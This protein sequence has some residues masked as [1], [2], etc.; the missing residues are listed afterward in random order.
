MR[1][2]QLYTALFFP[3]LEFFPT[4]FSL[5]KDPFFLLAHGPKNGWTGPR[6]QTISPSVARHFGGATDF[7]AMFVV[8]KLT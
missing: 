6:R 7:P 8:Q 2:S 1:G 5:A 4:G 3:S